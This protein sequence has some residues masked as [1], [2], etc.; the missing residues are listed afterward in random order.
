QERSRLINVLYDQITLGLLDVFCC[1]YFLMDYY[2]AIYHPRT[3]LIV[4]V[5]GYPVFAA[6]EVWF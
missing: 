5:S 3:N 4:E 6:G 2:L 1:H